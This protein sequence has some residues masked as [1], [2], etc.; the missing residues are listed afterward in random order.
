MCDSFSKSGLEPSASGESVRPNLASRAH[1]HDYRSAEDLLELFDVI[2]PHNSSRS[3]APQDC[4][5]T[6]ASDFNMNDLS[7]T[8]TRPEHAS[9]NDSQIADASFCTWGSEMSPT[10][11][12]FVSDVCTQTDSTLLKE[13]EDIKKADKSKQKE[14][15]ALQRE[16]G[17]LHAQVA[18]VREA[19][20]LSVESLA[21]N[22]SKCKY[23]TGIGSGKVLK[24]LFNTTR[25]YIPAFKALGQDNAFVLT[26]RKLRLNEPFALMS[27]HYGISPTTVSEI[28]HET[29][30]AIVLIMRKLVKMPQR[31]VLKKHM[32]GSFKAVYGDRVTVIIDCF[33]VFIEN[34]NPHEMEAYANVYS[35]YKRHNTVKTLIGVSC[36]GMIVFISEAYGGRISDKEIVIQSGF[37]EQLEEGDFVLADRGFLIDELVQSVGATISYPAFK[38]KNRQLEPLDAINSRELSSLR[39]HVERVI[40]VLRQKFLILSNTIPIT[41]LRRF[42]NGMPVIDQILIATAGLVNLCQSIVPH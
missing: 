7:S 10:R 41:V 21:S 22:D 9:L 40:G 28:F 23:F 1:A 38:K 25:K 32:P 6:S 5:A 18:V 4:W 24:T 29:L 15:E 27:H 26:L 3:E 12:V 33:E 8:V 16:I 20:V 34:P 39:I 30:N 14:V 36:T 13:I 17:R 42:S 31:P 2:K 19:T 37:I 35:N 11:R